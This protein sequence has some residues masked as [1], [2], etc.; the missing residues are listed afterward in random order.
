MKQVEQDKTN[1]N[2]S[3]YPSVKR[4]FYSIVEREKKQDKNVTNNDVFEKLLISYSEEKP[5]VQ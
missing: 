2:F 3:V 5:E 4:K 1:I